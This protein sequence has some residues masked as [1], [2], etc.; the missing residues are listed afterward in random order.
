MNAAELPTWMPFV[1]AAV[2]GTAIAAACGLRAFLPLLVLAGGA[3]LGFVQLDESARWIAGD[4]SILALT[5]ATVLELLADKVPAL[6]HALDAVSTFIRPA[7]AALAAW[8]G[9]AGLHPALGVVAG[10]I[11]G[12]G[13]LG[14]HATKSKVRLG[15][16]AFTLGAANPILSFVEDAIT[17][18]LSLLAILAPL[19]ALAMVALGV[20][21][22]V[23]AVR[24]RRSGR[25][26]VGRAAS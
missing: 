21:L 18:S 9:F 4:A 5:T 25:S 3:R 19:L 6:D 24:K 16:S 2:A 12:A 26:T 8:V 13:A 23:R 11:L 10:L 22:L 17:L 14:V 7:A 15:S 20:T 1:L